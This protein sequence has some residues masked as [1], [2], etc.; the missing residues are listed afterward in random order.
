MAQQFLNCG[1][2]KV[3]VPELH[4]PASLQ[5]LLLRGLEGFTTDSPA[6]F[7]GTYDQTAA[8]AGMADVK[9]T[10]QRGA[11]VT[12]PVGL[13]ATFALGAEQ[14]RVLDGVPE[15]GADEVGRERHCS[16]PSG[17]EIRHIQL[18]GNVIEAVDVLPPVKFPQQR[19]GVFEIQTKGDAFITLRHTVKAVAKLE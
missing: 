4:P 11:V 16:S 13:V 9:T 8:G 5:V 1:R 15:N 6:G 19:G 17:A 18:D 10:A 12:V 14:I 7:S 3:R 2:L